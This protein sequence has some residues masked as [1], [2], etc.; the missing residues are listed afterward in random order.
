MGGRQIEKYHL[1]GHYYASTCSSAQFERQQ[2]SAPISLFLPFLY[3]QIISEDFVVGKKN[4]RC[5]PPP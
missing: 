5:V 4:F 1:G 2:L 3:R